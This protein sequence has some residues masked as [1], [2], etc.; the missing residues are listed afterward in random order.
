[1]EVK[2]VN[3]GGISGFNCFSSVLKCIVHFRDNVFWMRIVGIEILY[4]LSLITQL[5]TGLFIATTCLISVVCTCIRPIKELYLVPFIVIYIFYLIGKLIA[6]I[7]VDI[8]FFVENVPGANWV[9]DL[10]MC[11]ESRDLKYCIVFYKAY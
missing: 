6:I 3:R 4:I 1:M 7:F 8:D 10:T 11:W 5:S 2:F 9:H